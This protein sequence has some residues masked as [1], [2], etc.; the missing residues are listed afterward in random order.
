MIIDLTPITIIP[1]LAIAN[2]LAIANAKL[3]LA[4]KEK[5]LDSINLLCYFNPLIPGALNPAM[6]GPRSGSKS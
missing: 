1:F 3:L 2:V 6:V 4:P 5:W